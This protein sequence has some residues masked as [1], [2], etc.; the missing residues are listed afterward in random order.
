QKIALHGPAGKR[1]DHLALDAKRNR[2]FVA[3]MANASFDV[4][5]VKEGK[6]LKEVPDQPGVQGIAYDPDVDRIFIGVGEAGVCNGF[7]GDR[8]GKLRRGVPA[9]PGGRGT[10]S[11]PDGARIFSGVGE[12]GV[13]NVFDGDTYKLLK[14]VKSPAADNARYDAPPRRVWVAHAEKAL[15]AI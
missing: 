13:C 1:L 15:S 11:A 10:A 3:N 5:D 8:G 6:L 9:Q 2:L 7:D 4:I 12:A 14:P